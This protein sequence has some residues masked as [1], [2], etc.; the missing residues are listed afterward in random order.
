MTLRS[1]VRA[2]V[3]L[4][5]REAPI[6]Q[7]SPPE[8]LAICECNAWRGFMVEVLFSRAVRISVKPGDSASA[9]LD[10]I[11]ATAHGVVVHLNASMTRGFIDAEEAFRSGL[12][13]RG[14]RVLNLDAFDVRKS[15]LHTRC[16]E[17]GVP[18]ARADQD[19][20]PD[21]RLVIK[22][23]LNYGG[24][25]ERA[26]RKQWG[27]RAAAFTADVGDAI[28][29]QLGYVVTTRA[30]VAA[31]VWSDPTLVVERFIE[32]P[33]GLIFRVYVAGPAGVVSCVWVDGDIK[34]LTTAIRRR[35][36]YF[37]W[38]LPSGE[39]ATL[40]PSSDRATRALLATRRIAGALHADFLGADC[41]MDR[42]DEISIVDVNKTPYWGEPRRSPILSHLRHG[43]NALVGDFT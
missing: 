41:V 27:D 2:W 30:Q 33:E 22:T 24:L 1:T 14:Q 5:P 42:H 3:G 9:L 28:T 4:G 23:T 8:P 11:P 7:E 29:T 25:P 16:S 19:G 43:F 12:R 15:T 10:A 20:P 6:L 18:S 32:N 17:L 21:E 26:L 34:K 36:N 37:F 13:E 38:T 31:S 35:H 39:T 40:G